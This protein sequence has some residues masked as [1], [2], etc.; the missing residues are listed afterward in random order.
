MNYPITLNQITLDNEEDL[1]DFLRSQLS[2]HSKLYFVLHEFHWPIRKTRNHRCSSVDFTF[3][4]GKTFH[5]EPEE[6]E[7][8]RLPIS[9]LVKNPEL[10]QTTENVFNCLIEKYRGSSWTKEGKFLHVAAF[11]QFC[12]DCFTFDTTFFKLLLDGVN[13]KLWISVEGFFKAV[14]SV[15]RSSSHHF[16]SFKRY[17]KKSQKKFLIQKMLCIL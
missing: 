3:H 15:Q 12:L 1:L 7:K 16:L 8:Q 4:P 5:T 6:S 14:E 9:I 17:E 13:S 10:C 11:K 2:R